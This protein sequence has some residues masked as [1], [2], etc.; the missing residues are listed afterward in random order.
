MSNRMV[1]MRG[2][3]SAGKSWTSK[4]ILAK[5]KETEGKEGV[6]LS[7]DE[8]FY[9]MIGPPDEYTFDPRRLG[10]AHMW[11]QQRTWDAVTEGVPLIIIDNTN[12]VISEARPYAEYGCLKDYEISIQE[13]TSSWWLT[14][15][16]LLLDKKSNRSQLLE[17]A[18]KLAQKSKE[19]HNVPLA[20]FQKM[21]QRWHN[22]MTVE[23]L[24]RT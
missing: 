6:I 7:T 10:T 9:T 21:I 19:T 4:E 11:N 2:F 3:P 23:E 13:P 12:T 24:L 18:N 17:W 20:V 14:I 16:D 22:N 5:F 1:I 15:H 8:Y